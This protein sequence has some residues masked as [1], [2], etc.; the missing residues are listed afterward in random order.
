MRSDPTRLDM[1][2][3]AA[4]LDTAPERVYE[5]IVRLLATTLD[6]PIAMVNILDERRDWFKACIGLPVTE[7]PVDTSFCE[8]FFD[9]PDDLIVVEDTLLSSRFA[10]HPLVT[11]APHIRFY[12]AARLTVKSQ[13]IGTLCAYHLKPQKV[14]TEQLS[15]LRLQA[16]AAMWL[17][18]ARLPPAPARGV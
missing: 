10:E 3:R 15:V 7:S 2:R 17:L 6:V 12:C 1:L 18:T 13:T 16:A 14:S 8:S 4:V 5:D 9:Q 11:S